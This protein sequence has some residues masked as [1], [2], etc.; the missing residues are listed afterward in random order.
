MGFNTYVTPIRPMP[1]MVFRTSLGGLFRGLRS[2]QWGML[3]IVPKM[4]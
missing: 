4:R 3:V 1:Y 2:G